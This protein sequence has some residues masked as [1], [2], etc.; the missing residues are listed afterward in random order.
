MSYQS[1]LY[2]HL[3]NDQVIAGY[4]GTNVYSDIADG[5]AAPPFIVIQTISTG[6]TT[7]LTGRREVI[8]PSIQITAWAT[9]RA[10]AVAIA[11]AIDDSIE[12]ATIHGPASLSLGFSG[13]SPQYENDTGLYA[14]ILEYNGSCI[15]N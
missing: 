3:A 9:T 2:D 4:V 13:Q 1:D 10:E 12:G 8:F 6:G 15:N 11:K 14:E 5:S 7:P